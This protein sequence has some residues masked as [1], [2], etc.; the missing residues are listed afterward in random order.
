MAL[1]DW[2]MPNTIQVELIHP[3]KGATGVFLTLQGE[4]TP[5]FRQRTIE[6]MRKRLEDKLEV[7]DPE[8]LAEES[9]ALVAASIAGWSDDEAFDG[10]YSEQRAIELMLM[11]GLMWIREQVESFRKDRSNFFRTAG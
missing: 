7:I 2:A 6:I 10:P 3:V 9:A 5:L 1:K 4:D 11:P 8:R